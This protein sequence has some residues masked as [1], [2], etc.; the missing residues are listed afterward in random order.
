MDYDKERKDEPDPEGLLQWYYDSGVDINFAYEAV[1]LE[2]KGEKLADLHEVPFDINQDKLKSFMHGV[3]LTELDSILH[4][5]LLSHRKQGS[6]TKRETAFPMFVSFVRPSSHDILGA[7][8]SCPIYNGF[9]PGDSRKGKIAVMVDPE[10]T[11][12]RS[13]L[14]AR[15][16]YGPYQTHADEWES[17][18]DQIP[19]NHIVGLVCHPDDQAVLVEKLEQNQ[20]LKI[21]LYDIEGNMLWP[22]QKTKEEVAAIFKSEVFEFTF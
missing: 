7:Y 10:Y 4:Q 17:T 3:D 16:W 20:G 19:S 21:K 18:V 12:A 8:R 11:L 15:V 6:R 1:K 2:L 5:G 9:G 14:A 22:E 13:F